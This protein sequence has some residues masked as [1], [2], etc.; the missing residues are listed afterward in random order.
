MSDDP[1]LDGIFQKKYIEFCDDLIQS[2]PERSTEITAARA[3]PEPERLQ[4]YRN[5][6]L[7]SAGRPDRNP[8]DNPG[9][10]LPGVT[11]E[12]TDWL[13]FSETSKRAIQEYITL[14]SF[15]CMF[16]D[17][18]HPWMHDLSGNGPSR[19]WM[20]EMMKKLRGKLSSV[21]FKSLSEKIMHLFG[22]AGAA[23]GAGFQIPDRFLKGQLA[24]LA[25]ELVREFKP[26]DFGL[27]PEELQ[28]TEQN[29]S[30]AFDMLMRIYTQRPEI[31]QNAMKR[32]A[33][34]LQEKIRKGEL[35]PQEI[36]AEAEQMIKEFSENPAFVELMET[37]RSVFGFEDQDLARASGHEGE[38]RL[39]LA[40][41][42]LRAKL[43]AKKRAAE[44]GSAAAPAPGGGPSGK[45]GGRGAGGKSGKRK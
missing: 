37:F 10:V 41:S 7:P 8:L 36:A 29:P 27:S 15:C 34:R 20:D 26:E 35:R 28:E 44:G 5:E 2:Y 3:L 1:A 16:G 21:D 19:A 32:I 24:K 40:R 38:G 12:N 42:R 6:V 9:T 45:G 14:L 23:G 4:R 39:A 30:R 11:I 43:E 13:T 18:A 17:P 33:N 31:L 25:E 22:S